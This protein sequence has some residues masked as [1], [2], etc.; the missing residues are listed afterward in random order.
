MTCSNIKKKIGKHDK[1]LNFKFQNFKKRKT[2]K[3]GG[4]EIKVGSARNTHSDIIKKK[5]VVINRVNVI[6][7]FEK[8]E[9][10]LLFII[11]F[12][13]IKLLVE[14]IY[15]LPGRNSQFLNKVKNI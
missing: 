4:A 9:V 2:S 12:Y 8:K 1:H 6:L 11:T 5:L 13:F 15:S 3:K 10:R 7:L 14:G